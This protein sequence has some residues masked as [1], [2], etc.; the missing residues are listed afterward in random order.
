MYIARPKRTYPPTWRIIAAF[1]IAP[2]AAA[3][4]MAIVMPAYDGISDPL[5][6]LW[7]STL[8]FAV[9]GAY[10]PTVIV[11]L[12]AFFM[13][14]RHFDPKLINCSLTGAVV[15]AIPWFLLSTLTLPDSASINGRATVTAGSLTAFGWLTNLT[16]VG[17]IALLG[18]A[19][20][21]LFWLIAA[22]GSRD[23]K[24]G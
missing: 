15:A 18:A 5:E 14:R 11:G 4:L 24:V 8:A 20:G 23:G 6:R 22:A 19:G 16:T 1:V 9:F 10:P 7:R 21:A 17:Q 3:L 12:P 2:G 13:L